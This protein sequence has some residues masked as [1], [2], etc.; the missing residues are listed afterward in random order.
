MALLCF[1]K[2]RCWNL[3][4]PSTLNFSTV[5]KPRLTL[6]LSVSL[7]N[8]MRSPWSECLIFPSFRKQSFIPL[9][10]S[11]PGCLGTKVQCALAAE[12]WHGLVM[13]YCQV[14][15]LSLLEILG[16]MAMEKLMQEKSPRSEHLC[17]PSI[18]CKTG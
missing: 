1:Q 7:R 5:F 11:S 12:T 18:G 8:A 10:H 13:V 2:I 4:I 16:L 9:F 6:S 14:L 17:Y 15:I 3:T